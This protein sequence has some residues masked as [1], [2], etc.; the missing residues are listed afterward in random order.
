MH[1]EVYPPLPFQI[2]GISLL[3]ILNTWVF[4]HR[5]GFHILVNLDNLT[6]FNFFLFPLDSSPGT[7]FHGS[8]FS[9]S[10]ISV[11]EITVFFS[12]LS[13]I[14]SD[15][16]IVADMLTRHNSS[17]PRIW[18]SALTPLTLPWGHSYPGSLPNTSTISLALF[19]GI[20]IN[21]KLPNV[22]TG[23]RTLAP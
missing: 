14:T 15:L 17:P 12:V 10:M 19:S 23:N 4:P 11:S 13:T 5:S 6:L 21:C 9:S 20:S 22:G 1:S 2:F 7:I 3:H 8:S 18:P 16:N